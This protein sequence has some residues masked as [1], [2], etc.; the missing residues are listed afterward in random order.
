MSSTQGPLLKGVYDLV[1]GANPP[2]AD[3]VFLGMPTQ[4]PSL[5]PKAGDP[6]QTARPYCVMKMRAS[7]ESLTTTEDD[8]ITSDVIEFHGYG[9]TIQDAESMTGGIA[10]DAINVNGNTAWQAISLGASNKH[11]TDSYIVGNELIDEPDTSESGRVIW[12]STLSVQFD[13]V[14]S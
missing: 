7:G 5:F 13:H 1:A 3:R 6:D 14:N 12:H 4:K 11:V 9:V 8:G 2:L 10:G